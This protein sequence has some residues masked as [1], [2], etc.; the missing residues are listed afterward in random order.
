MRPCVR[1]GCQQCCLV[2]H[3]ACL[4]LTL[5][6]QGLNK[7]DM[8]TMVVGSHAIGGFRTLSS[9]GLTK[10]P[11]VP[12]DC[13]PAGQIKDAPFDNNVFK[14]ACNGQKGVSM[15]TCDWNVRCSNTMVNETA[16]GCP[17]TEPVRAAYAACNPGSTAYPTPG[18]VSGEYHRQYVVCTS[19]ACAHGTNNRLAASGAVQQQHRCGSGWRPLLRKCFAGH[20]GGQTLLS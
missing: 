14:V 8:V 16:Q 12:F 3:R 19:W 1:L 4:I 18:M 17:F 9:P 10:C 20:K 15:G 5:I 2:E 13:T 7:N 11:Y 6:M